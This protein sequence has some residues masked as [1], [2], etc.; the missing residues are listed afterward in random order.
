MIVIGTR[1]NGER[2]RRPVPVAA[3]TFQKSEWMES[4]DDPQLSPT[5]F[6]VEQ[7][8][9]TTLMPHFHRQNQ[10]QLFVGGGGTIGRKALRPVTV[11][12]AGAYTAYGPLVAGDEGIRYFTI[13]P[14]CESGFIPVAERAAKMIDGPKRHAQSEPITL[15]DGP[16][17]KALAGAHAEM[18]IPL[19]ED[20]LGARLTRLG[21]GGRLF[22]GHVPSSQGQFLVVLS[23][24]LRYG[25][26]VLG[27][28][29][30][31]FVTSDE[32]ALEL[33]AGDEGAEVVAM[34][35]PRKDAA[36]L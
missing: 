7:P 18:L 35:T 8:P 34:H 2:R 16:Q 33:L 4:G 1:M 27:P 28:W 22:V 5:V 20:G 6:L 3:D 12:Y 36:Y 14:V 15:L 32:P 17:R 31:L 23:G 21:A 30:N 10:F 19:G 9:N 11:H 24:A 26:Q 29:E 25:G 13:R